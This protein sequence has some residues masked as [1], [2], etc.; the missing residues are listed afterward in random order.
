M[1]NAQNNDLNIVISI[2]S[3]EILKLEILQPD[4]KKAQHEFNFTVSINHN[5]DL[6]QK[7]MSVIVTTLIHGATQ[8]DRI[9]MLELKIVYA[10]SDTSHVFIPNM[11][12][13]TLEMNAQLML[14]IYSTSLSTTRG[15]LFTSLKGTALEKVYL[16]IIDSAQFLP[17]PR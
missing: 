9:A 11:Q 2:P 10:F 6:A 14:M 3:I 12:A 5:I 8:Q 1:A 13:N 17:I 16:P 7:S 4:V 15:V